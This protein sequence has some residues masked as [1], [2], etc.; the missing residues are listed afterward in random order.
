MYPLQLQELKNGH[1]CRF[2]KVSQGGKNVKITMKKAI[3][4]DKHTKATPAGGSRAQRQKNQGSR[5]R[6]KVRKKGFL[7]SDMVN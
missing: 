2:T 1:I 4:I 7:V 6:L 3:N 5:A